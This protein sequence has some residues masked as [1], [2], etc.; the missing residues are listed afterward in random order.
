MVSGPEYNEKRLKKK[1]KNNEEWPRWVCAGA[2]VAAGATM[3]GER[4]GDHPPWFTRMG[5]CVRLRAD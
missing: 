5:D 3:R 4:P 1:E 2:A